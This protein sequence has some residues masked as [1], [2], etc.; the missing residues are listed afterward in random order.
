MPSDISRTLKRYV[1]HLLQAQRENM[2]EADTVQR[3]IKVFEDVLGYDSMSEI[4]REAQMKNKFVDVALKIDGVVRLLVEAKAAGVALRDRHIEQ[5][6]SY[7]SRNNFQWVLLTNGVAWNLYHLTFDEGIEY[8]RAFSVDLSNADRFGDDAGSLALL[9]RDSIRKG[10]HEKFWQEKRALGPVSIGRALFQEEVI[11]LI[12]REIRRNEGLLID[13]E[14][15]A[16]ALHALFSQEAR[17]QMGP[18]KVRRRRSRRRPGNGDASSDGGPR[19][20]V[21]T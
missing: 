6:Q 2:N 16:S 3:L 14:D 17:E 11:R 12:R 10:V 4:S 21:P 18:V 8:E 1:P 5:A 13:P 15:L 20:G 7:A 19:P 9:H